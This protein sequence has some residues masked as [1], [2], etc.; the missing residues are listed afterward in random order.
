MRIAAAEG[1]ARATAGASS[2]AATR[3]KNAL[4]QAARDEIDPVVQAAVKSAQ[5]GAPAMIAR[6]HWRTFQVIDPSA[7]D[8]AVRQE[9]YFVHGPDAV[10][11]ASYTDAR[12]ELN[13]EHIAAGTDKPHVRPASREAEY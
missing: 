11:W 9:P 6:D 8:A 3:I 2:D 4:A 13:S 10:V 5:G 12:G 7:D 1:L